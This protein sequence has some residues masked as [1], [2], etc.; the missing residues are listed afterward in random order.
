MDHGAGRRFLQ[1]VLKAA[2]GIGAEV[3]LTVCFMALAFLVC[4]FWWGVF[5]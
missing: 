5:K 4:A 2:A 1:S 3:F